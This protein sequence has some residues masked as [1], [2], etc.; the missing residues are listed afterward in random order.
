FAQLWE[1]DAGSARFLLLDEPS[2]ALDLA[3]QHA[4]LRAVRIFAGERAIGVLMVLH[5]LN[6]AAQ[7]ADRIVILQRGRVLATGTPR[8]VLDAG[9]ISRSF[10]VAAS[11]LAH[12]LAAAPLIATAA[13]SEAN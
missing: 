10:G 3:H 13:L 7:Y 8:D 12:P 5:D 6:L 1:R 11:V 2:A 9:T 4:L